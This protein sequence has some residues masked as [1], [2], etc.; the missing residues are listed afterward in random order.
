MTLS[1]TTGSLRRFA[2]RRTLRGDGGQIMA[3]MA[4]GAV[5]LIGMGA[6]VIDV[7]GGFRQQRKAQ[8]AADGSALAAAQQLPLSTSAASAASAA[9][10]A[11]NLPDG[12]VA[13]TFASTYVANDTA[14]SQANTTSPSFFAKVLGFSIFSESANAKAIAG[15]YTGWSKG[16]SPW[17]TD[18][19]SIQVGPDH[20]VQGEIR[21]PGELGQ[22]RRRPAS[23]QRAQLQPGQRRQ[24]LQAS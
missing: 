20:P 13:T 3:L 15:S 14:I 2:L 4:V 21:R 23:H 1:R 17:V 10:K 24:R 19:D 12:T 22:L 9:V 5:A 7:G 16:M 11:K 18:K 6:F 8:S